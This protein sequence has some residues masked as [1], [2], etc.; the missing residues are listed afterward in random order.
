MPPFTAAR[1][2]FRSASSARS[3]ATRLASKTKPNT[4]PASPFRTSPNN[5]KPLSQSLL[6]RPVGMSFC[7]ESMMPYHTVTASALMTSMLSI[8]RDGY[9]WLLE[10]CNDDV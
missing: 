2:I 7:V 6:R 10:A 4:S 8:S 9:G 5:K 3:A 1:S